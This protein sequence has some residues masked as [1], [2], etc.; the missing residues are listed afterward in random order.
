VLAGFLLGFL[1]TFLQTYLPGNLS[2]YRDAMLWVILI[3]VLLLRPQGLFAP[4]PE[5]A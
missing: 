1:E 2:G 3:G 5:R 4:A